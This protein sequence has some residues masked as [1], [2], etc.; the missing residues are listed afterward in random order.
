MA[1]L[2]RPLAPMNA[3]KGGW[4]LDGPDMTTVSDKKI[5]KKVIPEWLADT[6]KGIGHQS[7]VPYVKQKRIDAVRL[8]RRPSHITGVVV[9]HEVGQ[10]SVCQ[11]A[12]P[13]DLPR[14]HLEFDV[15]VDQQH[16]HVM[17]LGPVRDNLHW[18]IIVAEYICRGRLD[19]HPVDVVARIQR[20]DLRGMIE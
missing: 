6:E 2:P 19:R 15:R 4:E 5:R 8:G 17:L 7:C 3:V 16:H 10:P 20:Q 9:S 12:D 13:L 11:P 18:D 14:S 1:V